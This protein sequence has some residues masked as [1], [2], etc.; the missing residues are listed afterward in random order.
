VL[1]ERVILL[2]VRTEEVPQVPESERA[3]VEDLGSGMFRVSLA[4]GFSETPDIPAA[5]RRI[6]GSHFHYDPMRTTFFLGRET[7]LLP[8]GRLS[9]LHRWQLA[10]FTF[11]CRNALDPTRFFHLPPNR[12]VELGIQVQL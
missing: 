8:P 1:H 10:L 7:L 5:L 12:V 11:M 2:T 4:Y 6:G 9:P 3:Q